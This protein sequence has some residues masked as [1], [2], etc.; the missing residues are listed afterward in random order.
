MSLGAAGAGADGGGSGWSSCARATLA[1]AT[2]ATATTI[3]SHERRPDTSDGPGLYQRRGPSRGRNAAGDG[4][5]AA[6]GWRS[7]GRAT[8]VL[9]PS[10]LL[11]APLSRAWRPELDIMPSPVPGMQPGLLLRDPV[12][13]L[14]RRAGRAAQVLARCLELLRR[15]G[16]PRSTCGRRSPRLTGEVAVRRSRRATSSRRCARRPSSTTSPSSPSAAPRRHDEFAR[17]APA[18]RPRT[19]APAPPPP[20]AE[21]A[22]WR[23]RSTATSSRRRPGARARSRRPCWASRPRTS[24]PRAASPRARR[25]LPRGLP[26]DLGRAQ[27]S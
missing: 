8:F 15:R 19:R 20:P 14:G 22:P 24:A 4:P 3:E 25:R 27:R 17:P 9:S 26:E 6:E 11:A 23:R 10:S 16:R 2:T 13:L 18:P 1:G 12:P 21:A 7:T 5:H